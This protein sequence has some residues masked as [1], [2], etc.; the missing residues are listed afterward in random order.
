MSRTTCRECGEELWTFAEAGGLCANCRELEREDDDVPLD[1]E[2]R[3][4]AAMGWAGE[5]KC[6]ANPRNVSEGSEG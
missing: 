1:L 4:D 5:H 2:T 3:I 6:A